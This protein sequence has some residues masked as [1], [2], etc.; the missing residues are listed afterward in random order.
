MSQQ[1]A[2][3]ITNQLKEESEKRIDYIKNSLNNNINEGESA[4]I[5]TGNQDIQIPENIEKF[6]ISPPELDMVAQ[7]I[8]NAQQEMEEK[9]RN[10]YN[11]QQEKE[12]TEGSDNTDSGLWTPN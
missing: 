9:I 11:T 4:L 7:W 12:K 2:D 3:M 5:F 1:V 10:Q 6:I 8:K